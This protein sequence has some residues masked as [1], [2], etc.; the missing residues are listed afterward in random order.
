MLLNLP[1]QTS[2]SR[3][4][5]MKFVAPTMGFR[6]TMGQEAT[7]RRS[8]TNIYFYSLRRS[9]PSR[10]PF[11]I[12]PHSKLFG[13]RSGQIYWSHDKFEET[14]TWMNKVIAAGGKTPTFYTEAAKA[15]LNKLKKGDTTDT[16]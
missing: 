9:T 10:K 12:V 16:E 8:L 11:L 6:Y 7:T 14:K 3:S 13:S 4:L 5:V 1:T 2:C 15:R